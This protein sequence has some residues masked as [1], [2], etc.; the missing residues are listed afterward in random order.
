[1]KEY[2]RREKG[3]TGE[4]G[5]V[6]YLGRLGYDVMERN[7]RTPIGEIDIVAREGETLVFIE[8]KRRTT[9]AYGMAQEAVH[10]RKQ[11]TIGRV[12][13]YYVTEKRIRD[14]SC[15]FDV[16]CINR[17]PDGEEFELLK[18]AFEFPQAL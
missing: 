2:N 12:A 10:A 6:G 15:R 7:Y 18:N 14:Q 1:M 5:A 11:Q 16:V 8:V 3:F 13:L 17:G 9:T 4:T